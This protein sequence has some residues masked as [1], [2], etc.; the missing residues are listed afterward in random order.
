MGRSAMANAGH[1]GHPGGPEPWGRR[2]F[3]VHEVAALRLAAK[4][5]LVGVVSLL[6]TQ[7]GW[8]LLIPPHNISPLWPTMGLLLTVLV[9]TPA[10]HWWAYIGATFTLSVLFNWYS[11]GGYPFWALVF[12]AADIVELVV[13]AGGMRRFAGGPRAFESLRGL[14]AYVAVAAL[15]APFT[16]AFVAA[17]AAPQGYWLHW[18]VWFLSEALTYLTI[19][20][21]ILIGFALVHDRFHRLSLDRALEASLLA[22]GIVAVGLVVFFGPSTWADHVPALVYLPLPFL[23]WAAVRFGSIGVNP[24]LLIV[25]LASISGAILDRGPFAGSTTANNVLALQLF[26]IAVSV[27][28]MFLAVL[29]DE[30]RQRADAL[31]ESE[32]RF[33][34]M[35]DTAPVLIWMAGPDRLCTFFNRTWLDFTG[36]SLV[37]EVGQGWSDGVHV[38]DRAGCLHA[39]AEAFDARREF[40]LEYR[41][42][43]HDGQYRWVLDKGVPRFGP[44]RT[45]LGY[46]GSADDV[47]ELRAALGE[48]HGLKERL[49]LENAYLRQEI[50][51]GHAHEG[52]VGEGDAIR[53]VLA[54]IDQ[55]AGTNATVLLLGETGVGKELAARAIHRASARRDRALVKVN[56]AALP[57]TLI[58]SEL[59]GREKG[60]YT[61]AGTRQAG[62]FE[63]ADKSTIFLDEVGELPLELQ[64][65]LLRVV[66]EGEFERL[67][68]PMTRKTDVR[69]IAAS[70]RDLLAAVH[71]G[72]F[73][74]DL[75]HRLSVFPIEV[76]PLR[77][78]RDDIPLLV[79]FFL[80][81]LGPALGKNIERVPGPVME[82]LIAYDW[83]GNVRELRNV[84]ER[85]LIISR[86]PVL[87]LDDFVSASKPPVKS[88]KAGT[89]EH[90]ERDHI[91]RVLAQCEWR[92][93]GPGNAAERLGLNASTLYSRMKKLGIQRKGSG[94]SN[95]RAPGGAAP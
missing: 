20:P 8:A 10:R 91:L 39:F 12:V 80:G 94:S 40:T 95:A 49:E 53:R 30:R 18:R 75:Y 65:K 43:R 31:S 55:V 76:P 26:L 21:T 90:V 29:M 7:I 68:S 73:R 72:R 25:A 35:A 64:A 23:L 83:P 78:R 71:E 57:S 45:F 63:I 42:R 82:R 88:G 47:T 46:I 58:E 2:W 32:A 81:D 6:T 1:P 84:L 59:F 17:V 15:L 19:A 13:A 38:D 51:V 22:G 92:I 89:L 74:A 50:T 11:R 4:A 37:Q 87:S 85:A 70:N 41:L 79:W 61:G 9:W 52:I 86:G 36:R 24:C 77:V 60:A 28:L 66:Q 5:L 54:Q 62:R 14:V 93:R 33:R 27:P 69:V 3:A 56:C 48:V 34:S 16:S 44:D 67:G